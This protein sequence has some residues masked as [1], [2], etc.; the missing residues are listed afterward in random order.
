MPG[1]EVQSKI[2]VLVACSRPPKVDDF[3]CYS[4]EGVNNSGKYQGINSHYQ[5]RTSRKNHFWDKR[6]FF[7]CLAYGFMILMFS[8]LSIYLTNSYLFS[9]PSLWGSGTVSSP[10]S[11]FAT[12]TA[13]EPA[14]SAVFTACL[15]SSMFLTV[16][17]FLMRKSHVLLSGAFS[18]WFINHVYFKRHSARRAG[19]LFEHELPVQNFHERSRL[20]GRKQS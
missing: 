2:K 4:V 9:L 18:F 15:N 11:S 8:V 7:L 10:G 6:S 13:T 12:I 3:C 17:A 14:A 20:G 1:F 5:F 19:P 16:T